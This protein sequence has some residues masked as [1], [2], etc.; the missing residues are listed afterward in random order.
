MMAAR[1]REGTMEFQA[2]LQ[3]AIQIREQYAVLERRQYG[4]SWSKTDIA[5][6]FVGDVGD[7]VK[8]VMAENGR[9]NIPDTRSKLAH[10]LADCLWSILVLAHLHDVDLEEAFLQTMDALEQ[11]IASEVE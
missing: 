6:G 9:R 1:E 11:H 10:E 5:L 2:L 4:R 8:L 3:R 7:L